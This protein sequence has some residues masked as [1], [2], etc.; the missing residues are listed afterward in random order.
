MEKGHYYCTDS[1][2]TGLNFNIKNAFFMCF[3]SLP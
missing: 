1:A 3:G 2:V